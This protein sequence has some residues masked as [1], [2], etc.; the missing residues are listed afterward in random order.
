MKFVPAQLAAYLQAGSARRNLRTLGGD[1]RASTTGQFGD[2]LIAEAPVTGTPLMGKHLADSRLRQ[3]TGLTVVGVWERSRFEAPTLERGDVV[4]LAEAW[5]SSAIRCPRARR[6][7]RSAD[8]HPGGK[9]VQR[10]GPG[11][12]GSRAD[13]PVTDEPLPLEAELILIGTTQAERRFVERFGR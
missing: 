11:E 5:T 7:P 10:R 6:P 12:E 13:Q 9:R 3:A 8:A 4:M 2:L 1:M